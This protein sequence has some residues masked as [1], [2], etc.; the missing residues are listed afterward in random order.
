MMQYLYEIAG[1]LTNGVPAKYGT[2]DPPVTCMSKCNLV[3]TTW[4]MQLIFID[5]Q[6]SYVD[7]QLIYIGMLFVFKEYSLI[8]KIKLHANINKLQHK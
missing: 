4:D 7:M 6:Q 8:K 2:L 1:E 3:M 5:I